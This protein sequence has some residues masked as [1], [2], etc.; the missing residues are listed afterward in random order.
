MDLPSLNHLPLPIFV[1]DAQGILS[2]TNA[3]WQQQFSVGVGDSW[4]TVFPDADEPQFQQL[5]AAC[6]EHDEAQRF[7]TAAI[8]TGDSPVW[9]EVILQPLTVEQQTL[10]LGAMVDITESTFRIA[11]IQAILDTAVDAIITIDQDGVI[12]AFNQSASRMFGYQAEWIIGRNIRM[13][14]PEPHRSAHDGYIGRY[15]TT[16]D[17]RIIDIGRE[18]TAVDAD[19]REFPIYLA[20][21]EIQV[22]GRRRFTGI[23]RDLTEQQASREALAEQREKLAHVGRLSTMGEMT[24]SIAHEINQPL[25]AISMYA[26]AGLKLLERGGNEQKLKDAIEKLNVQALRAGAVIERIQRF[27][28]SQEGVREFIDPNALVLDLLKL[29]ESDARLHAMELVLDLTQGLPH[30]YVDPIQIQQVALNLIRNAIDA[31]NEINC[32]NG[33]EIVITS[34]LL[35]THPDG[36]IVEIAVSDLGPGVAEDQV[37][38]LFTPFHTTKRD[39][40]GMGLSICRSIIK[41]HGGE[42]N[43]LNNCV[44]GQEQEPGA[45]F[46]FQLPVTSDD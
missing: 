24:A 22:A 26:Q 17:A 7:N 35:D 41:E 14:M 9:F 1:C 37:D 45:T 12:E 8:T 29:A 2:F 38:L 23:V 20:V 16:G 10:L 42:L 31:M 15:L 25:T 46:Y 44:R 33:R 28:K 3:F 18:L 5:W 39:G 40:M 27:A 11:E 43:Y 19:D 34:R 13:L 32:R 6:T 4:Q 21:S 36:K 30:L